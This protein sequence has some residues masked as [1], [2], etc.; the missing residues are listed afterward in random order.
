[1]FSA[2]VEARRACGRR[3]ER[4]EGESQNTFFEFVFTK[5]FKGHNTM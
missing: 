1:M 3:D 2:T 5:F 4:W